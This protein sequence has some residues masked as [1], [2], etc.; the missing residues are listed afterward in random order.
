MDAVKTGELI[1]TCYQTWIET[2]SFR[3]FKAYGSNS[4]KIMLSSLYGWA[5]PDAQHTDRAYYMI[6]KRL[7]ELGKDALYFLS[8]L[9]RFYPELHEGP[10]TEYKTIDTD[11]PEVREYILG[12][13]GEPVG[14]EY[15]RHYPSG[16]EIGISY[17]ADPSGWKKLDPRDCY[18]YYL[19]PYCFLL[20][21]DWAYEG[22]KAFGTA[23]KEFMEAVIRI[24][25]E[26]F[27]SYRSELHV[28]PEPQPVPEPEPVPEP[29]PV[30]EP[31][32]APA[33]QPS[34]PPVPE[35]AATAAAPLIRFCPYCGAPAEGARFCGMC[36]KQ[37]LK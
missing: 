6:P 21:P 37:L 20:L 8:T 19:N 2:G 27:D 28:A 35:P 5:I 23:V 29:Q 4:A 9:H 30:P 22:A 10:L 24:R 32:P 33:L 12:I 16:L 34:T 15:D 1:R 3:P 7:F 31:E 11:D 36:G 17:Y 25:P 13:E 14:V 26:L 18:E